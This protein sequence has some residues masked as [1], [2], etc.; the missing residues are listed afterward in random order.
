[1]LDAGALGVGAILSLV[2]SSTLTGL[3]AFLRAAHRLHFPGDAAER[4]LPA[5]AGGGGR[6]GRASAAT[7]TSVSECVL[8]VPAVRHSFCSMQSV[9]PEV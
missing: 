2:P 4:A 9:E 1:M 3:R 8:D 5:G 7:G 6:A